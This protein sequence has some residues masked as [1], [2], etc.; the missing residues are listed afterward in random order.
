MKNP[1]KNFEPGFVG[2]GFRVLGSYHIVAPAS[3]CQDNRLVSQYAYP[4]SISEMLPHS[5]PC[6]RTTQEEDGL[7]Q[8]EDGT[9]HLQRL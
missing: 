6:M 1:G 7:Q 4:V 5:A 2:L 3:S 8:L 9:C